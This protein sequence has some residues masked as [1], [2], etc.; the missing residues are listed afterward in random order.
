MPR[1]IRSEWRAQ[2][3]CS[4]GQLPRVADPAGRHP[5][6]L[7]FV[8]AGH[9]GDGGHLVLV[10]HEPGHESVDPDAVGRP[11]HRQGLDQVLHSSFGRRRV[12]EA[13]SSGPCVGS[14]HVDDRPFPAR[15]DEAPGN[16]PRAQVS[17]VQHDV[18]HG[19]PCVG[20]HVLGRHRKVAGRV[21]DQVVDRAQPRL[22]HL[23]HRG[24]GVGIADVAGDS[25]GAA[26]GL[27][28][29]RH[30]SRPVGLVAA[31]DG[32][33]SAEAPELGG[34]RLAQPGAAAGH[35]H[36]GSVIG[37]IRQGR[38]AGGRGLGQAGRGHGRRSYPRVPPDPRVAGSR[39]GHVPERAGTDPE[40]TATDSGTGCSFRGGCLVVPSPAGALRWSVSCSLARSPTGSLRWL[41][42]SSA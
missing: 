4:P 15:R 35:D 34:D 39:R 27:L 41:R 23:E 36:D 8:F 29:R 9:G 30:P 25:E 42:G 31:H 22:D 26:A 1:N 7:A 21:V 24:D 10:R 16:L 32:H 11:F 38:D 40:R 2:V 19:A 3:G 12:G 14:T 13:R 37:A 6:V 28:D 33:C 5:V 20:A 17:P 18:D